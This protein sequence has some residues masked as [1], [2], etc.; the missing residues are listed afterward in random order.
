MQFMASIAFDREHGAEIARALPAEQVRVRELQ[1]QGVLE[2]LYI[3][4]GSGPPTQLWVVFNGT[5]TETVREAMQTLPLYPYMT[6]QLTS[7]R[8]LEVRN[9]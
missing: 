7:L 3:P 4:D 2:T 1:Q 8:E 9:Q 5:S 6:V